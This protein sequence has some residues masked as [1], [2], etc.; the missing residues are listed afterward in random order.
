MLS[1]EAL[2]EHTKYNDRYFPIN[3][4]RIKSNSVQPLFIHWHDSI[5]IVHWTKGQ[6]LFSI[7]GTEF[8]AE[9]GDLFC[10]SSGQIHSAARQYEGPTAYNAMVFN[11][12]LLMGQTPDPSYMKHLAP[13]LD[14]SRRLP[15]K[16]SIDDPQWDQARFLM[17]RIL[18]EFE[19]SQAGY[20]LSVKAY[21]TLL[22]VE[23]ARSGIVQGAVGGK[24]TQEGYLE[25]FKTL[26]LHI[27]K[28]YAEKLTVEHAA[29]MVGLSPFHFCKTFKRLTGRTFVEFI[30]LHRVN[31]A[32]ALLTDSP[33]SITEIAEATGFC[34]INYLDRVFKKYKLKSPSELR[35][36]G[37]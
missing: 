28:N 9:P 33:L 23:I 17:N 13:F 34:N 22:L 20:E 2:R 6:A 7:G 37:R 29:R 14:G 16:L 4:F 3:L 31:K 27:E 19:K 32:E 11:P 8:P 25:N 30:N 12:V 35:R 36:P 24:N 15:P 21:L 10:V 26:L 1:R 18:A 5:E